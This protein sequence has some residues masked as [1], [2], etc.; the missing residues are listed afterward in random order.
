MASD[1]YFGSRANFFMKRGVS[2][3]L[4]KVYLSSHLHKVCFVIHILGKGGRRKG[5]RKGNAPEYRIACVKLQTAYQQKRSA[6]MSKTW[7]NIDNANIVCFLCLLASCLLRLIGE[8]IGWG[9]TLFMAMPFLWLSPSLGFFFTSQV[10]FKGLE[11]YSIILIWLKRSLSRPLHS[12]ASGNW[13]ASVNWNSLI[14]LSLL[15]LPIR[16]MVVR[17]DIVHHRWAIG[18]PQYAQMLLHVDAVLYIVFI[19][20]QGRFCL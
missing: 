19:I 12:I 7:I 11:V 2:F 16:D 18:F 4:H 20:I 6:R 8:A 10:V 14:L 13:R 15:A 5:Q 3:A 1:E 9:N 17:W